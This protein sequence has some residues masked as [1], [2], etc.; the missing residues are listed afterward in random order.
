[1][2]EAGTTLTQCMQMSGTGTLETQPYRVLDELVTRR[3]T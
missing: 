1:M 2:S 3:A